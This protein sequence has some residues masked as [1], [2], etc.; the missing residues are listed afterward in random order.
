MNTDPDEGSEVG[1]DEDEEQLPHPPAGF[2]RFRVIACEGQTDRQK[3]TE[4]DRHGSSK[5]R[6]AKSLTILQQ[7]QKKQAKI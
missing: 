5:L 7:Q 2:K 6:F 4:T 1:P 3:D